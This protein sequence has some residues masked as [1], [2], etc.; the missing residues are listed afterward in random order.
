MVIIGAIGIPE[1]KS[2]TTSRRAP[3]IPGHFPLIICTINMGFIGCVKMP[4]PN[5]PE[6]I[7]FLLQNIRPG[8]IILPKLIVKRSRF[9]VT[10]RSYMIRQRV[11]ARHKHGPERAAYRRSTNSLIQYNALAGKLIQSGSQHRFLSGKTHG[12]S[13]HLVG[14]HNHQVWMLCLF[15]TMF[16][17]Y[18]KQET[19]QDTPYFHHIR[20]IL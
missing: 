2:M 20:N 14:K 13:P 6:T 8:R 5:I 11:L 9:A 16:T 18:D 17:R 4:L 7:S 1:I 3:F 15:V 19:E 10:I 12:L